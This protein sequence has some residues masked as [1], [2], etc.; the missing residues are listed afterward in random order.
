M[1]DERWC[2]CTRPT[3]HKLVSHT[4]WLHRHGVNVM[5]TCPGGGPTPDEYADLRAFAATAH[6]E[7]A[8][9]DLMFEVRTLSNSYERVKAEVDQ[10]TAERDRLR[11]RVDELLAQSW[12]D[13]ERVATALDQPEETS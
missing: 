11:A 6:G 13:P 3:V 4:Y 2:G 9:Q 8:W 12:S 1:T 5:F 10:L 7:E